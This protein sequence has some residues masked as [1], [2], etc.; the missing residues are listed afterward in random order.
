MVIEP[1]AMVIFLLLG[2]GVYEIN[3]VDEE[4]IWSVASE[5]MIHVLWVTLSK[6]LRAWEKEDIPEKARLQ[7]TVKD[8]CFSSELQLIL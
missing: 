6:A 5:S 1:S 8:D 2:W 4:V 7:I 3:F